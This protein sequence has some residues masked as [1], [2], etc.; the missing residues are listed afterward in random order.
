MYLKSSIKAPFWFR[1]EAVNKAKIFEA[2]A[3][4]E[5]KSKRAAGV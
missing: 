2:R 3:A 4:D 5:T 1:E